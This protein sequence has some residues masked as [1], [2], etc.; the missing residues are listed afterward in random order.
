MQQQTQPRYMQGVGDYGAYQSVSAGPHVS[1]PMNYADRWGSPWQAQRQ[2]GQMRS[3][4]TP[5]YKVLSW[6]PSKT[7]WLIGS[8]I[9]SGLGIYYG[10]KKHGDSAGWA[11]GWF[12]LG[13]ILWPVTVPVMA[14]GLAK[15]KS[16]V[17]NNKAPQELIMSRSKRRT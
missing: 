14:F 6:M 2:F 12:L 8:V 4:E 9:G 16:A 15:T 11:V 17:A 1:A 5:A 7:V 10:Y 13:G 3:T